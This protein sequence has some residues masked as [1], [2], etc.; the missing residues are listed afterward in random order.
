MLLQSVDSYKQVSTQRNVRPLGCFPRIDDLNPQPC[1]ILDVAC[2]DGEIV[3]QRG[4]GNQSVNDR[5]LDA[6]LLRPRRKSRPTVADSSGNGKDIGGIERFEQLSLQPLLQL[7]P[8]FARRKQLD[9]PANLRE[10]QNADVERTRRG[11]F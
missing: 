2:D 10:S 9:A 11:G 7:V 5:R 8:P 4:C 3:F 6:F 1:E